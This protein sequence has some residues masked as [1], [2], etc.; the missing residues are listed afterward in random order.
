MIDRLCSLSHTKSCLREEGVDGERKDVSLCSWPSHKGLQG[1]LAIR[2]FLSDNFAE[3]GQGLG[4]ALKEG[5]QRHDCRRKGRN[6]P[7]PKGGHLHTGLPFSAEMK[8]FVL[9][10]P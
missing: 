2:V 10:I 5:D 6:V 7:K 1:E 9:N 4:G 8:R 3:M